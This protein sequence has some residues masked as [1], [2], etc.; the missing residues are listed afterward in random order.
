M[1]SF[2]K[3]L[4]VTVG[5]RKDLNRAAG[6]HAGVADKEPP[7]KVSQTSQGASLSGRLLFKMYP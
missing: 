5:G 7:K 3:L 6:L 2:P 4:V 1:T